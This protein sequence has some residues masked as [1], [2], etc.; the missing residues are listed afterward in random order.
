[1]GMEKLCA[2]R[3][4]S[5]SMRVVKDNLISRH[6]WYERF[7]ILVK[8]RKK[9]ILGQLE[10]IQHVSLH[11]L[12]FA[13]REFQFW[14]S[15]QCSCHNGF[16]FTFVLFKRS[17]GQLLNETNLLL[18]NRYCMYMCVKDYET[19]HWSGSQ[20][21]LCKL[22]TYAC[23]CCFDK[24]VELNI[25]YGAWWSKLNEHINQKIKSEQNTFNLTKDK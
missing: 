3:K 22:L 13:L 18:K 7:S 16:P 15:L 8:G 6:I 11:L 25:F 21:L 19:F 9:S 2:Y 5:Q 1:M 10:N 17:R 20:F 23:I 24:N 12:Y 4:C 14:P